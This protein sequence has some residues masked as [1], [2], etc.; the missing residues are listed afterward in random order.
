[1]VRSWGDGKTPDGDRLNDKRP[2]GKENRTIEI[3]AK[4]LY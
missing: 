3:L 2:I 4:V 1:M